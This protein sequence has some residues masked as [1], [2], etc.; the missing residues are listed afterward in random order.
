MKI[1]FQ[2]REDLFT[3]LGGDTVQI[4]KTKQELEKLGYKIDIDCSIDKDLSE[5]DIVH[6]FNL[7]T[8]KLT[9]QQL[10][11]AKKQHKKVVLSTIWW[12]F[13]N[14]GLDEDMV[15]YSS[16]KR[17]IA[18]Y[19]LMPFF[20]FNKHKAY[21]FIDR[22]LFD[23]RKKD[24]GRFI[25]SNADLILPN[26]IAELEILVQDFNMPEL[27]AK[28]N[29]VVNAIDGSALSNE[30]LLQPEG[31]P[32]NYVLCVGRIQ[33]IK[34]QAKIIKALFDEVN[35]PIV[36]IGKSVDGRYMKYVREL[37]KK[38]TN[39]FFIPGVAH[40]DMARY[41]QYARV[42]VLPSLRES[43]G[44]VSLEAALYNT[45]IVVSY[46]TPIQEY[47]G[48]NTFV[49]DP[50]DINSIRNKTLQAYNSSFSSKLKSYILHNL[51]WKKA[52][53]QTAEGYQ[54]LSK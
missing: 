13:K 14:F 12:D 50:E 45:N 1:L 37:A 40:E 24:D 2:S 26:S 5:Y 32:S 53:E 22:I 18:N 43:P 4:L 36:F 49:C 54:R 16:L 6:I 27:R 35:I 29:I 7:Q 17:R 9:K 52:A 31:I 20:K 33:P 34:G 44:L 42:H 46:Q 39:V 47:F 23:I 3:T 25:L 15:R 41:Y 21:C 48:D 28:A 8:L 11:N 19:L 30:A 10:I 51:T 38:R